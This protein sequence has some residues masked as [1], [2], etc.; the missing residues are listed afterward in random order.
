[1]PKRN[2]RKP[3]SN[4]QVRQSN[5]QLRR[6]NRNLKKAVRKVNNN[7]QAVVANSLT[8]Q[9]TAMAVYN[10][11]QQQEQNY[12]HAL[13]DPEYAQVARF[14]V[15]L[16]NPMPVQSKTVHLQNSWTFN[17]NNKGKAFLSWRPNYLTTPNRMK[18][19]MNLVGKQQ[20]QKLYPNNE[21]LYYHN[22]ST[23]SAYSQLTINN[24]SL[25]T[26]ESED[27]VPGANIFKPM[28]Q[29]DLPI[30]KYRLVSAMLK[31]TYH[32]K[33][34]DESGTITS[35]QYVGYLRPGAEAFVLDGDY[36]VK[37]DEQT[38]ERKLKTIINE[39]G[40]FD[41]SKELAHYQQFDNIVSLPYGQRS[42]ILKGKE[43]CFYYYPLDDTAMQFSDIGAIADEDEMFG[44]YFAG[45]RQTD[46]MIAHTGFQFHQSTQFF[47]SD[48][49]NSKISRVETQSRPHNT[50]PTYLI[51]IDNVF[52]NSESESDV[53]TI[54]LYESYECL[55]ND[56][57][58][59]VATSPAPVA[60]K[61][62]LQQ[63]FQQAAAINSANPVRNPNVNLGVSTNNLMNNII[64]GKVEPKISKSALLTGLGILG[65]I[66]MP[67]M[68]QGLNLV[69]H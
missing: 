18:N 69:G 52:K 19:V 57:M 13:L 59:L 28:K 16:P 39:T 41:D 37:R 53:F 36:A 23:G 5:R 44:D 20:I 67:R 7:A 3:R 38:I 43:Y 55:M 25:L 31:I 40:S 10:N 54:T 4:A 42:T 33:R 32:G 64:K 51:G 56:N 12:Y 14:D 48:S 24:H 17:T 35:G 11:M 49:P 60:D 62:K 45:P 6:N 27:I 50:V 61:L 47:T 2:Y 63:M 21:L 15:K 66:M 9:S 68:S 30:L 34:D 8:K 22:N 26:G 1:M 65:G 58:N 46:A 29:V